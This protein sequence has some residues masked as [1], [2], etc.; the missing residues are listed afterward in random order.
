MKRRCLQKLSLSGKHSIII[1]PVHDP[2]YLLT[3]TLP[4]YTVEKLILSALNVMILGTAVGGAEHFEAESQLLECPTGFLYYFR[5][6]IK[7]TSYVS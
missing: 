3:P 2:R 7:Q 6:E 1:P 5:T 4:R